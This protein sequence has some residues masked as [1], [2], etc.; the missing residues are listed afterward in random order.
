MCLHTETT[1]SEIF[2]F[3]TTTLQWFCPLQVGSP[4]NL[5]L[6]PQY[7]GLGNI[8]PAFQLQVVARSGQAQPSSAH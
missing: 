2:L 4:A 7:T 6:I 3:F 1:Q 8:P 5:D